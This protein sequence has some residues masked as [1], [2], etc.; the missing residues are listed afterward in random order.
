[1]RLHLKYRIQFCSCLLQNRSR[2]LERAQS[3]WSRHWSTFLLRRVW[4]NWKCSAE[5]R[6]LRKDIINVY[7]YQKGMWKDRTML[8]SVVLNVRTTDNGQT[9]N[10]GGSLWIS[11]STSSLCSWWN[12]GSQGVC[13]IL[14][15]GSLQNFDEQHILDIPSFA[16]SWARWLS[17]VPFNLNYS[18][19]LW[20]GKGRCLYYA[21]TPSA[22]NLNKSFSQHK[23]MVYTWHPSFAF[24]VGTTK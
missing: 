2:I 4:E 22:K 11:G 19:I 7:K 8:F 6:K 21:L 18:V 23:R 13:I 14:F 12:T 15:I 17:D 1:M 10:T 20:Y 24:V 3:K 16:R 9:L 5:K